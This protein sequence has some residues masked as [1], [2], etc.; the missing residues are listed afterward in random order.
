MNLQEAAM[1]A[2]NRMA[3]DIDECPMCS[4]EDFETTYKQ[5]FDKHI[6]REC[7]Y[8]WVEENEDKDS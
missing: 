5:D 1:D 3:A 2:M 7:C 6:C 8:E 4:N